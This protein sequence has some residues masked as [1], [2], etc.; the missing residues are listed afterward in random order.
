MEFYEGDVDDYTDE[1]YSDAANLEGDLTAR[2]EA[3]E[4]RADVSG[5]ETSSRSMAGFFSAFV[6]SFLCSVSSAQ[7]EAAE[8]LLALADNRRNVYCNVKFDSLPECTKCTELQT[9]IWQSDE[10]GA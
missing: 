8:G 5:I 3:S 4:G 7:S 10:S 9:K 6:P 2:D 1:E